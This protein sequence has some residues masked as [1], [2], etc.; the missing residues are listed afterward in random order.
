MQVF[1]QNNGILCVKGGKVTA[2]SQGVKLS[3]IIYAD[4]DNSM[5]RAIV[6]D[7]KAKQYES[8]IKQVDPDY[9]KAKL[10][11]HKGC[12]WFEFKVPELKVIFE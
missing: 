3:Y 6:P 4:T 10:T 9:K 8:V 1:I 12:H 11:E 7:T 2:Y 5:V